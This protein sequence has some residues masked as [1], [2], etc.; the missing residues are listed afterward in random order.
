MEREN[1]N[2]LINRLKVSDRGAFNEIYRLYHS[3]LIN[4]AT[5]MLSSDV[6]EDIV[7]D[8]F[9]KLWTNRC[10]LLTEGVGGGNL[11]SW[12]L[13]LTYNAAIDSIRHNLAGLNHRRWVLSG[14]E[15][16]YESY[17][18]DRNDIMRKLYSSDIAKYMERAIAALPNKCREVFRLSYVEG[19]DSR[20]IGKKLGISELTV[21]NHLHNA[22]ARLR[23]SLDSSQ[24]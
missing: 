9:L 2:T 17:N 10:N 19:M 18:P 12:L 13:R 23:I 3:L 15:M 14:L 6:A 8:V 21:K 5:Q 22:L 4:Y 20:S 16:M 1:M 24:L 11:R 7:Q